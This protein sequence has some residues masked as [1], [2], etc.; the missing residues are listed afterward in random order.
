[1]N[2]KNGKYRHDSAHCGGFTLL[3]MLV[4]IVVMALLMGITFHLIRPSEHARN[5]SATVKTLGFANV[6]I[7]EYH[8]EYG[9]YPPVTEPIRP[10]FCGALK[11]NPKDKP[12]ARYA[13]DGA[14]DGHAPGVAVSYCTPAVLSR[15]DIDEYGFK[16]GLAAYLI[17][18]RCPAYDGSGHPES[19]LAGIFKGANNDELENYFGSNSHWAER[20]RGLEGDSSY[21]AENLYKDLSPGAKELNFYKRIKSLTASCV[22]DRTVQHKKKENKLSDFY[23]YTMRDAWDND[24]VYICPPPHTSYALFS[25]GPD[26]MCVADDPLNPNAQ[27]KDCKGFHNKDNVYNSVNAR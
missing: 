14:T 4:V 15:R 22:I 3:E 17:D 12:Y 2:M 18:R 9:I 19:F 11:A 16:F 23:C 20:G 5:I 6:A 8:A 13:K 10:G 27:C 24:L 7:A 26:H 1:M 25:A 21:T